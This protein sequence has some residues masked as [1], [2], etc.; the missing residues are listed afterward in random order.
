MATQLVGTFVGPHHHGDGVPTD[1]R[2]NLALDIG[3]AGALYF[4]RHRNG[5]AIRGGDRR[6][7]INTVVYRVF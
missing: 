4:F 6:R 5:V 7:L 3:I 2:A 1:N